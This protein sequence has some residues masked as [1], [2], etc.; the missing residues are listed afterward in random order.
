VAASD[1][2]LGLTLMSSATGPGCNPGGN[3][4]VDVMGASPQL[5]GEPDAA[6]SQLGGLDVVL[7]SAALVGDGGWDA[8]RVLGCRCGLPRKVP[9]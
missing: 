8:R 7:H 4:T 6:L 2:L 1:G 3:C 9:G 5:R